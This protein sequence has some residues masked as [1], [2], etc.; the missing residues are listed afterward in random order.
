MQLLQRAASAGA[1]RLH[2]MSSEVFNIITVEG[3]FR[4]CVP[5]DST[6]WMDH[7]LSALVVKTDDG[8]LV[9][10]TYLMRID[11]SR[12]RGSE[13]KLVLEE[14]LRNHVGPPYPSLREAVRRFADK[15]RATGHFA[16]LGHRIIILAHVDALA[17]DLRGHIRMIIDH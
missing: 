1:S 16:R 13:C 10:R 7:E 2:H 15:T 11:A 8:G 9:I 12:D 3:L 4:L 5:L 17:R 14:H 6:H